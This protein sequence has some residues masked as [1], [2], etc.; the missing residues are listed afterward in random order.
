MM[1]TSSECVEATE[2]R[3]HSCAGA[4]SRG[5]DSGQQQAGTAGIPRHS[6]TR[7]PR[8]PPG[9]KQPGKEKHGEGRKGK[10]PRGGNGAEMET[11][12]ERDETDGGEK[13]HL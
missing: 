12:A 7:S 1:G 2:L 5:R 9:A 3:Q 10:K 8:V 6:I 13:S 11:P 4:C